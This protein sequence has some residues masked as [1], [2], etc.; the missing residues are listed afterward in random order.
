MCIFPWPSCEPSCQCDGDWAV[1]KVCVWRVSLCSGGPGQPPGEAVRGQPVRPHP[2]PGA[3]PPGQP[4]TSV[5]GRPGRLSTHIECIWW[6]V[7]VEFQLDCRFVW[8]YLVVFH[9]SAWRIRS[10]NGLFCLCCCGW[11]ASTVMIIS[12]SLAEEHDRT[13]HPVSGITMYHSICTKKIKAKEE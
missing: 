12:W 4:Q 10:G 5:S 13:V 9:W 2:H 3:H 7:V 8:V 11:V 1:V 6:F